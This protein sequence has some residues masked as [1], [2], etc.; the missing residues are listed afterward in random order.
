MT[1][2]TRP[3]VYPTKSGA[4]ALL[5]Q[6]LAAQGYA[7]S[8]VLGITP[9]GVEI[10]ANAAKA[11]GAKFDVIVASFVE[12]G[13]TPAPIGAMAESA[14]AEMD[15]DFLPKMSLLEQL[16]TAID[17]ARAR[18]RR[19]VVLY[20]KQREIKD[21][22][23]GT[24]VVVDGYVV[25]PWKV[26]AA[27]KVAE[28]LGARRVVIATPVATPQAAERLRLQRYTFVCPNVLPEAEGNATPFG[29]MMSE[30]PERLKAVM[31]ANQAA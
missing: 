26:L 17:E 3:A 6:Q 12:L 31:I 27:A 28:Q 1:S 9:A 19:D 20:R 18:V 2:S 29:D 22:K 30:S 5:G 8:V 7:S 14:P 25:H 11:M 4:G 23:G 15:P 13:S 16:E 24:A 21:L 10:A